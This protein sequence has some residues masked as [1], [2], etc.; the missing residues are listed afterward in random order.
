VDHRLPALDLCAQALVYDV[1]REASRPRIL[2]TVENSAPSPAPVPEGMVWIPGGEF[3]MG[4]QDPPDL[5]DGVGMEATT[6]SRPIHRVYVDAFW[7]DR[8]EVTNEQFAAFVTATGYV[9][10]AE[11]TPRAEDVPGAPKEKLVAGSVVFTPPAHAVPLNLCT[12]QYCSRHRV[13]TRGQ[14]RGQY[15]DQPPGLPVRALARAA[16]ARPVGS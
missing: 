5:H 8:A 9:P 11:R 4:A 14:G 13:G 7:M 2:P 16:V 3:S 1:E 12:D 15:G 6:D 10:I